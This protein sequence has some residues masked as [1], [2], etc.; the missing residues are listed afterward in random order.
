MKI[1]ESH[2]LKITKIIIESEIN[3]G[4]DF[5]PKLVSNIL[6][7]TSPQKYFNGNEKF[8]HLEGINMY[9]TSATW[10]MNERQW[11]EYPSEVMLPLTTLEET[12]A[13]TCVIIVEQYC[14]QFQSEFADKAKLIQRWA[15]MEMW[16][17]DK[18]TLKHVSETLKNQIDTPPD[19]SAP[20]DIADETLANPNPKCE[21]KFKTALEPFSYVTLVTESDKIEFE[22]YPIVNWSFKLTPIKGLLT[23]ESEPKEIPIWL[24]AR[25]LYNQPEPKNE[26][27]REPHEEALRNINMI[28]KKLSNGLCVP[29]A[30]PPCSFIEDSYAPNTNFKGTLAELEA[31]GCAGDET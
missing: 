12:K 14:T 8:Q 29:D 13:P 23:N 27:E 31:M 3:P 16:Q 18:D 22:K 19:P 25:Q 4:E 17:I 21:I 28:E 11:E 10:K 30:N 26:T 5:A 1:T 24:G 20:V 15:N 9:V 7:D 2:Y 6:S